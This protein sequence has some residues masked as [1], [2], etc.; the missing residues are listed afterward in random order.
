M[1][2]KLKKDLKLLCK[3]QV[4]EINIFKILNSGKSKMYNQEGKL[5][6]IFFRTDVVIGT[7]CNFLRLVSLTFEPYMPS[8]SAKI[9][10]LL[11]V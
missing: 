7:I 3:Y 10:F 9:N 6:L 2:F 11:G 5:Y 8:T 4:L 1:L